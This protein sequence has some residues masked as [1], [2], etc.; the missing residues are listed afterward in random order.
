MAEFEWLRFLRTPLRKAFY[1][2]LARAFGTEDGR[3]ILADSSIGMAPPPAARL[4]LADRS[5]QPYS[6]LGCEPRERGSDRPPIFITARF[7]SG[8]TLLWS[9]FRSLPDCT[10]FYEP[11]NERRWFDPATRG[12]QIDAT[13]LGVSEYWR[14]YEGLTHLD[15]WYRRS[16]ID[17]RLFMDESAWDPDLFSYVDALIAAAR[18]RAVLQFNR[19]DF[20]LPW[21]R[22]NFPGARVIHLYRHPRDQWCSSLVDPKR[23]PRESSMA[24]FDAHDHF[25]LLAWARD[26]SYA[27]PFLDPRSAAHPYDLFYLIWKLS[28]LF[29]RRYAHASFSF[30]SLCESPDTELPRLMQA[31]SVEVYDMAALKGLIVPQKSKWQRYADQ[32]WFS[33]REARCEA[34]LS[35]FFGRDAAASYM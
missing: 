31:S 19:V 14:E 28:Y 18:G 7:R 9:L 13:H 35:R 12:E 30:E 26:L 32:Q 6:D 10:A 5:A 21:L 33:E 24:G 1:G 2:F 20:R 23:F 27:F 3:R 16:W 15:R 17:R 11:L 22:R 34:V 29:G 4:P 25:Y 8:S